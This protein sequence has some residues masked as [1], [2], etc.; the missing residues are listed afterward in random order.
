MDNGLYR[1]MIISE[2]SNVKS[3]FVKTMNL[4]CVAKNSKLSSSKRKDGNA[5]YYKLKF[6]EK[7]FKNYTE[8]IALA[9]IDSEEL[10]FA[11]G[12]RSALLKFQKK[13]NESILDIDRALAINKTDNS[14]KLKLLYRKLH[15]LE[16]QYS[17][18][19][20]KTY[21][22]IVNLIKII[23]GNSFNINIL[24]KVK[25]MLNNLSK[26]NLEKVQEIP[27]HIQILS[28]KEDQNPFDF[29]KIQYN[30]K[31]GRC[32]VST[33]DF[34][35]GDII[36]VEKAYLKLFEQVK[37]VNYCGHCFSKSW[38]NIPCDYCNWC[39]FCSEECKNLAW[40]NY[41]DI[42]CITISHLLNYHKIN[43]SDF[44]SLRS[45]LIRIKELGGIENFKAD[46]LEFVDVSIDNNRCMQEAKYN[47]LKSQIVKPVDNS[48]NTV[49][50]KFLTDYA[51]TA[52][53]MLIILTKTT[54]LF[55]E[56][57]V[58]KFSSINDLQ[59]NQDILF[60]G[61]VFLKLRIISEHSTHIV[62]EKSVN[63]LSKDYMI[64][65]AANCS[66]QGAYIPSIS[67][68]ILQSHNPNTKICITGSQ[69]LIV[70]A[71]QSIH[72]N[73]PLFVS[74]N[75]WLI[76]PFEDNS[77]L[78]NTKSTCCEDCTQKWSNLLQ[79]YKMP[80][81]K[82]FL[83]A[84]T[85]N[86]KESDL[87]DEN[88]ML[89]SPILNGKKQQFNQST[90]RRLSKAIDEASKYLNQ[91]SVVIYELLISLSIVFN[92]LYGTERIF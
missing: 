58:N 42:E 56:S 23:D 12:N 20:D 21:N 24:Y 75:P 31:F 32:L 52:V 29:V 74:C 60:I 51:I 86:Q 3:D 10:A 70:L 59:T 44:L 82:P 85:Y 47:F 84:S 69:Q 4:E 91:P 50:N 92:R 13:Y 26:T 48:Y 83:Y 33:C 62:N 72:Q 15:C 89:V 43:N 80:T 6:L 77:I 40:K 79:L 5:L 37:F 88:D 46:N 68:S 65:K 71:L 49:K 39:M 11:Y 27:E 36:F 81:E 87:Y 66:L 45:L 9:P 18:N 63:K 38:T 14:H 61:S 90:I 54:S 53:K 73:S 67:S 35:P 16:A 8:S 2:L 55:K 22:E 34:K 30:K 19:N 7:A 28:I 17:L 57:G 25:D 76:H 64:C 78:E 1:N 41:H